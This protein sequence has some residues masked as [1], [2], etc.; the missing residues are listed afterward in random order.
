VARGVFVI[1][2]IATDSHQ[3]QTVEAF[4]MLDCHLDERYGPQGKAH[5]IAGCLGSQLDNPLGEIGVGLGFVGFGSSAVTEQI[6]ANDL[7][8]SIFEEI[9]E[10]T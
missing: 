2:N 9:G 10:A 1:E 4:W 6:H 8:T 3:N 7:Q 5:V